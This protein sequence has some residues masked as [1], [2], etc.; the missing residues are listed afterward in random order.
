MRSRA[1]FFSLMVIPALFLL[2]TIGGVASPARA[3]EYSKTLTL[4]EPLPA[5]SFAGQMHQWWANQLEKRT[6]GRVKIK[7]YWMG[8]LVKWK[9]ML[10]GVSSGIADIGLVASTY[11]PSNLPLWML[12]DM[13]YNAK[14]YWAGMR[15]NTDT[16]L[17]Q[18]DVA[19]ELKKNNIIEVAPWCSGEFHF[20]SRQ[21][22]T[23]LSQLKGKTFRS[24]GGSLIDYL[25]N[26]GINPV[27]MPYSE[28]YEALNRGTIDGNGTCVLQL[29]DALKNYEV[30]K[31][32][33]N[34]ES[35]FVVGGSSL[36][37]N[38]QVW[39]GMPKDIQHIFV[40]LNYEIAAHWAQALDKIE[41]KIAEKW[42]N[43]GIIMNKLSPADMKISLAAAKKAQESFLNKL[44][45]EGLPAR[46]VW[47]YFRSRVI[48]YQTEV[49]EK[50]YPWEAK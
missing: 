16:C 23:S 43:K 17:Y 48:K 47:K 12:V 40:Q 41:P 18:P 35:G 36:C 37:M 38:R 14:D 34:T 6:H 26:L 4:A 49:K 44:E 3:K 31:Q 2:F 32:C 27:F 8:S 39:D 15:A 22:W 24:Y 20:S 7:F 30:I 42:K 33:T 13:P 5:N 10:Y 11:T 19:A 45:S 21:P 9:D 50:G 28:I 1:G 46:R 25:K 29:S